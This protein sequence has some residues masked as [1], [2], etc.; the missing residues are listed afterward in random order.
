MSRP[1]GELQTVNRFKDNQ[2]GMDANSINLHKNSSK[3]YL[4]I[5][6][7][8]LEETPWMLL[9]RIAPKRYCFFF[10]FIEV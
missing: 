5:S 6:T 4:S 9:P 1:H 3:G 8:H 2:K 7:M 10:F